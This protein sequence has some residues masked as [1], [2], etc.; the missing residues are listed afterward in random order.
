MLGVTA[1]VAHAAEE[2]KG[3]RQE[4]NEEEITA[5]NTATTSAA[6]VPDSNDSTLRHEDGKDE[7]GHHDR[8]SPEKHDENDNDI[9][10]SAEQIVAALDQ[11]RKQLDAQIEQFR[12]LKEREYRDHES[13]LRRR[14]GMKERELKSEISGAKRLPNG[15][16]E[17]DGSGVSSIPESKDRLGAEMLKPNG[18]EDIKYGDIFMKRSVNPAVVPAASYRETSSVEDATV[19]RQQDDQS[20][21]PVETPHE[22]EAEFAGVFTPSF[23]P[24]LDASTDRLRNGER[25]VSEQSSLY[26]Q[27]ENFGPTDTSTTAQR[28]NTTLPSSHRQ[29]TAEAQRLTIIAHTPASHDGV[30]ESKHARSASSDISPLANSANSSRRSSFKKSPHPND[31]NNNNNTPRSPKRVMFDIDNTV[32]SPSTSPLLQRRYN[33]NN[34]NNNNDSSRSS[35]KNSKKSNVNGGSSDADK[36]DEEE[37]FEI[38]RKK[39]LSSSQ[40]GHKKH[41]NSRRSHHRVAGEGRNTSTTTT[42]AT[43]NTSSINTAAPTA[44]ATPARAAEIDPSSSLLQATDDSREG[45]TFVDDFERVSVSVAAGM[46]DGD[47][48]DDLFSFD[49]DLDLDPRRRGRGAETSS[50]SALMM[51]N[52]GRG[53]GRERMADHVEGDDGNDKWAVDDDDDDVSLPNGGAAAGNEDY[54]NENEDDNPAGGGGGMAVSRGGSRGGGAPLTGSSPHAG[55]LPIEIRWP[56]RRSMDGG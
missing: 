1:Q 36:A 48:E 7:N 26:L 56:G 27:D 15:G 5:T 18:S 4:G 28:K 14:R 19:K 34:N 42:A 10:L 22:R 13:W 51:V 24:L 44:T 50:L 49:E 43:T 31:K 40:K 52:G 17:T 33:G 25:R 46:G 29:A 39:P 54:E 23:L 6:G 53:R 8:T 2:G 55:S 30:S 38:V 32:V 20:K 37:R 45:E 9:L 35:K 11:K 3:E 12:C 16:I 47:G 21:S 41:H